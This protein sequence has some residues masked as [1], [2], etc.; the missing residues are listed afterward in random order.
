MAIMTVSA[1]AASN[2]GKRRQNNEDNFYLNGQCVNSADDIRA[3]ATDLPEAVFSVCDGM[4]G[5]EAG[6]VA[7]QL[8]VQALNDAYQ[9]LLQNQMSDAA[10]GRYVKLA[11]ARVCEEISRRKKRLG[12][13]CTLLGIQNDTV[14]ATNIGDSRIYRYSSGCLQQISHDHTEAQ[15]M[16]D[17]GAISAEKA[18]TIPE[19]HRLTQHIGIF[20]EEML[21]EPFTVRIPARAGDRYL[22]CSDGLTDML[23]DAEIRSVLQS[24]QSLQITAER[25]ISQAL[26]KGGRDNVTVVL[27][28]INDMTG[29]ATFTPPMQNT[30]SPMPAYP[31]AS[32]MPS[33]DNMSAVSPEPK[34]KQGGSK[35]AKIIILCASL[36]ILAGLAVFICYYT[37]VLKT[38]QT[39]TTE[40]HASDNHTTDVHASS[41][42]TTSVPTTSG[43]TDSDVRDSD[44]YIV[45]NGGQALELYTRNPVDSKVLAKIPDGTELVVER[46]MGEW[47]Y[48]TYN[49]M[50]G[51]VKMDSLK[52]AGN[53]AADNQPAEK[54]TAATNA[55]SLVIDKQHLEN[56]IDTPIED[57]QKVWPPERLTAWGAYKYDDD[58]VMIDADQD[59]IINNIIIKSGSSYSLFGIKTDGLASRALAAIEEYGYTGGSASDEVDSYFC[60]NPD[61]GHVLIIDVSDDGR[62]DRLE[63][64]RD[65]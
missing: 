20:P 26:E 12:T 63:L 40:A 35:K 13:T 28:E 58:N 11:N 23:T 43:D 65:Q 45:D 22:L 19:K 24:G 27:C 10:I 6:E 31:D 49:G 32:P 5:E 62:I 17:S 38:N 7:S 44:A 50:K 33:P 52:K 59:G 48:V 14:T 29:F 3:E 57:L 39:K 54:T 55:D 64:G 18:M 4:G 46:T 16:V 15:T 37:G 60:Q 47:G 53:T 25:L 51:R 36:V 9:F 21:I 42:E 61:S 30:F 56:L 34:R 8:A 41:D 2:V 1:Y